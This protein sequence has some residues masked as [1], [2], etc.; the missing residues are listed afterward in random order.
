MY[1]LFRKARAFLAFRVIQIGPRPWI[2]SI[3]RY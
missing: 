2:Y 3:F 1:E